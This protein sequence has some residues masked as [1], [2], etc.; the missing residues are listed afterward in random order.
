MSRINMQIVSWS[1]KAFPSHPLGLTKSRTNLRTAII[2]NFNVS[3]ERLV[4]N[5]VGD[6]IVVS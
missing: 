2:Q 4:H 1:S 5:F 6:I 3:V